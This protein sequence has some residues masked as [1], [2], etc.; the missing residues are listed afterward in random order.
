MGMI[1]EHKDAATNE[2][3]MKLSKKK[4]ERLK[5]TPIEQKDV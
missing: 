4:R 3:R 2:K 1:C 5:I